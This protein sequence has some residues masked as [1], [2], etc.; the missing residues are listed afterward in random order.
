MD[1]TP[2]TPEQDDYIGGLFR[3][4]AMKHTVE[5]IV[6]KAQEMGIEAVPVTDVRDLMEDPHLK[7]RDYFIKIEHPEL[8]D[9][10]VYGGAP[11]KSSEMSWSYWRRAPF[12][13]EHNQEI[14]DKELGISQQ[15]LGILKQGGVI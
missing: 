7:E 13:G 5:E 12:I 11:F 1:N 14:Y 9:T 3:A 10:I 4:F 15:E 6:F 8:N 2:T